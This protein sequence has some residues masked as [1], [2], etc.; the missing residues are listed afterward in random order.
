[1]YSKK[2]KSL[3]SG[4]IINIVSYAL[5]IISGLFYLYAAS[6]I[7]NGTLDKGSYATLFMVIVFI[8]L[9]SVFALTFSSLSLRSCRTKPGNIYEN[10]AFVVT[11]FICNCIIAIF[12]IIMVFWVFNYICI[13]MAVTL[14]ISAG[15]IVIDYIAQSKMLEKQNENKKE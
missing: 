14:L 9:F 1:M 12:S 4:L 11:T 6:T 7:N 5:Y 2:R 13:V 15:L 3:F 8:I 10:Q